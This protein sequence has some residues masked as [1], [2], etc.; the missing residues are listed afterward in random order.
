MNHDIGSPKPTQRA[1]Q[2]D[3]TQIASCME[4]MLQS[5]DRLEKATLHIQ[6]RFSAVL[7]SEP[8]E[9]ACTGTAGRE[10]DP[11]VPL[12]AT[13]TTFLLRIHQRA[14]LLEKLA[15]RCEL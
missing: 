14:N 7:R 11:S 8:P 12:A 3:Q 10:P 4:Q 2:R 13:L 6:D 9:P 1:P 5:L 15:E